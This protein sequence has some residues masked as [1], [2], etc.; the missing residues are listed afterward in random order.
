MESIFAGFKENIRREIRKAEKHLQIEIISQV[1]SLYEL[2]ERVYQLNGEEYP[3]SL[4][5]LKNVYSYCEKFEAGEML[6]AK[7]KDGNVH[8]IL[9]YVWDKTTL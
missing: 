9:L 5:L 4:Q 8:S 7:D 6:V 3:I 1:E 2:K